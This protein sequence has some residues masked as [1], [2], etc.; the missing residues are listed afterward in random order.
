MRKN[1]CGAMMGLIFLAGASLPALAAEGTTLDGTTS[2]TYHLQNEEMIRGT[3]QGM[4]RGQILMK[5][6]AGTD[7]VLPSMSLFWGT[8]PQV[9][10]SDL[11]VGQPLTV[12]LPADSYL[13]VINNRPETVVL[14]GYNGVYHIA[15]P[16][17]SSW[18]TITTEAAGR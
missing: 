2:G 15:H 18:K 4:H 12:A 17:V 11:T 6:D 10:L 1:F 7:I 13:R 16:T 3:Y 14:G 8:S 5:T 9:H